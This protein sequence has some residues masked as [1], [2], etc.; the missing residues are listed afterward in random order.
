[1]TR[2]REPAWARID[3]DYLRNP[4]IAALPDRGIIAHLALLLWCKEQATNGHVPSGIP[5]RIVLPD[6]DPR[7]RKRVIGCLENAGLLHPEPDGWTLAG[8][9][10]RNGDDAA[11]QAARLYERDR[12]REQR[13]ARNVP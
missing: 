12:K 13:E 10:E 9:S 5:A 3:V 8:F 1:M 11:R 7:T 4:K 6:C 2:D